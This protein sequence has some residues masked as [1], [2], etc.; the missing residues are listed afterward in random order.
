MATVAAMSTRTDA[1][2]CDDVLSELAQDP[3][4]T[5]TDITVTVKD[6]AVTLSGFAASYWEK[7]E[8]ENATKRV[9]G[10]RAVANDITVRPSVLRTDPEIARDAV[11]ALA[12]HIGIPA[13]SIKVTIEDGH[14]TLEGTV[15]WPYQKILAE[16]V[17]K[18]LRGVVGITNNIAHRARY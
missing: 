5:S 3:R 9:H 8:A 2:I 4:I 12:S 10:V 14:V 7:D 18:S 16:S 13:K 17:V 15:D 1:S 6:A 11:R